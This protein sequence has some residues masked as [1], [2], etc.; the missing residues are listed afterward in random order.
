MTAYFVDTSFWIAF[1]IAKDESHARALDW[2]HY[3]RASS[4]P[5]LT[6]EFV[7]W[8]LLNALAAELTRRQAIRLYDACLADPTTKVVRTTEEDMLAALQTYRTRPDKSWS[9]TDCH[10]F[11]IMR[12]HGLTAALTADHHFQQAGFAPLLLQDPPAPGAA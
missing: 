7:L 4:T 11:L 2:H 5:L 1:L 9:L 3:L 8:E 10:S 6:T 12:A